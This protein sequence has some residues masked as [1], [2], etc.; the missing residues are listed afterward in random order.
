MNIQSLATQI[1]ER[2]ESDYSYRLRFWTRER[3]H[4]GYVDAVVLKA[5]FWLDDVKP[6]AA[7]ADKTRKELA[8]HLRSQEFGFIPSFILAILIKVVVSL[9]IDWWI[10]NRKEN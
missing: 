8:A 6:T 4:R 9:I 3:V 2:V 7:D 1:Q 5:R 10:A